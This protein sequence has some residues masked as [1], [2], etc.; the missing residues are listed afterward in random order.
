MED[1]WARRTT[2]PAAVL[3]LKG[4]ESGRVLACRLLLKEEQAQQLTRPVSKGGHSRLRELEDSSGVPPTPHPPPPL[5]QARP[6]S[7]VGQRSQLLLLQDLQPKPDLWPP[8]P[9]DSPQLWKPC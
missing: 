5:P 1:S 7:L 9:P 8:A 4:R 3:E 2:S 6:E